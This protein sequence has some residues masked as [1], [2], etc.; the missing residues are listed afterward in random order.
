MSLTIPHTVHETGINSKGRRT[1][2]V[3]GDVHFSELMCS[4]PLASLPQQ[5][6]NS[7]GGGGGGDGKVQKEYSSATGGDPLMEFTSSG[8]T[9]SWRQNFVHWSM[10]WLART[11]MSN[12]PIP[13]GVSSTI[14]PLSPLSSL[15][16][17]LAEKDPSFLDLQQP[18]RTSEAQKGI[19]F[20]NSFGVIEV[21]WRAGRIHLQVSPWL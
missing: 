17:E 3:S 19:F 12:L 16:R 14:P 4:T 1:I 6:G 8:L 10:A 13:Y 2:L 18:F 15:E 5:Q 9:H 11:V 21:D 7:R 20:S